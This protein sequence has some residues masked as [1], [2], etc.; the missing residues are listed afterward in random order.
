MYV[1]FKCVS[2]YRFL[3]NKIAFVGKKTKAKSKCIKCNENKE[4]RMY[5]NDLAAL[6]AFFTKIFW[7]FRIGLKREKINIKKNIIII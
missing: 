3:K 7:I 1:H 4:K 5:Q 2:L 6:F